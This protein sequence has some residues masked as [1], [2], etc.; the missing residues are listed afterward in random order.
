MPDTATRGHGLLEG[1]LARKRAAKANALIPPELR[2]GTLVD[3]GCG[4]S[5][6]FL[7]STTAGRRIGLDK[8]VTE[9]QARALAPRG[10]ELI[11]YDS[12][13]DP[14]LPFDD[15]SADVV[16]MLAVFE[17]IDPPRLRL[18]LAEIRRALRPGG[19]Y[20]LTTPASWTGWIL[21]SFTRM[22]LLSQE[23]I[24]EHKDLYSKARIRAMLAEA[25]FR[26][27]DISCGSF[28][29]GVNL[30]TVARKQ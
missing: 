27:E 26:P 10:V 1:F 7:L 20:V 6:T 25:G 24:H 18:L 14:R 13:R 2:G 28:E 30:W 5:P 17:H 3:V 11:A 19:A 4:T 9:E 16:T 15:A 23:E 22:G 8:L 21:E 12:E 29:C